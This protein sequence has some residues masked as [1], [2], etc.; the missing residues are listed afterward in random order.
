MTKITHYTIRCRWNDN[1]QYFLANGQKYV[2]INDV[3]SQAKIVKC[4]VPKEFS[5]GLPIFLVYQHDLKNIRDGSIMPDFANNTEFLYA[6]K[7]ISEISDVMNNK[8]S[9]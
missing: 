5:L 3:L 7:K 4:G 8:L 6:N 1:F 2:L 9:Y